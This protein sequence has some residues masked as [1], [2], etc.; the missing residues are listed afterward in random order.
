MS[1]GK[2]GIT[3]GVGGRY[4]ERY[5]SGPAHLSGNQLVAYLQATGKDPIA[6]MNLLQ[7]ASGVD[8][9]S[10]PCDLFNR[11]GNSRSEGGL[12]VTGAAFLFKEKLS[13][14][15]RCRSGKGVL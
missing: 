1:L 13:I 11:T 4:K 15:R 5:T 12:W 2:D 3:C 7:A 9:A 14:L 10:E 6:A 8:T